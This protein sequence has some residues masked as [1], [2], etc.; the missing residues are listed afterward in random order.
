MEELKKRLVSRGTE[1]EDVI[2]KRLKKA[3][4]EMQES[5]KYDYIVVNNNVEQC[6]ENVLCII[7]SERFKVNKRV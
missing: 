7:R 3:E 4:L 2:E 1:S 5:S 6:A